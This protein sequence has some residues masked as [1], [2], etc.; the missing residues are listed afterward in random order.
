VVTAAD[1]LGQPG[2]RARAVSEAIQYGDTTVDVIAA[3]REQEQREAHAVAARSRQ[4]LLDQERRKAL[5]GTATTLVQDVQLIG[6]GGTG[7]DSAMASRPISPAQAE[8][9]TRLGISAAGITDAATARKRILDRR[10]ELGLASEKQLAL[11]AKHRPGW[12]NA[13]T[14]KAE[15]KK[16]TRK[17]FKAWKSMRNVTGPA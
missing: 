13:G 9:M 12:I 4:K 1:V 6:L 14:T 17:L 11:L 7:D 8:E 15:A 3:I 5:T 16:L 10:A 2:P